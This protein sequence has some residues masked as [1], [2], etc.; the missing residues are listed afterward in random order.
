MTRHVG[1]LLLVTALAYGAQSFMPGGH[2]LGSSGASLGF[3][4]LLIAGLQTGHIFRKLGL[5]HLTG[6]LLCGMFFGP[7]VLGLVSTAMLHDL[8]LVKHVAV[9]LIALLAGCELNVRVLRPSLRAIG[10][11]TFAAATAAALLL[12]G[13]FLFITT[14]LPETRDLSAAQRVAIA[15]VCA[16]VLTAFSP[17]V[18][19]G[20]LAE[21]RAVGPLSRLVLSIVVFADLLIA[22][23]FSITNTVAAGVLPG[24][25]AIAGI[26]TL[27]WQVL[28]SL[29]VGALVGAVLGVY[30]TRV[31]RRSGL[32]V[33]CVLFVVAEAGIAVGIDSLLAGLAAGVF[34][35]NISPVSGSQVI[36]ETE[37]ATLPTFVIFF[38]VIGAEIHAREFLAVAPWA[39]AAALVRATGIF[40]GVR[41]ALRA[42]GV[43]RDIG[44]LVPFGLLPQAGVA[45]AL[46][47]LVR[48][49]FDP[50][51]RAVSTL[52]LGTIVVNELTGPVLFRMALQRANEIPAAQTPTSAPAGSPAS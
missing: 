11:F 9:G 6:Y 42:S 35:E 32:V 30:I 25:R 27:A 20:I 26:E 1:I 14:Q 52:L 47:N 7:P 8:A 34:L 23:A 18:V 39:L 51:G 29:A 17:A 31:G 38:G 49:A 48:E 10:G 4:F 40:G 45:L 37:P 13:L 33:L 43:P 21:T 2:V 3:G 50:W 41:L 16:N 28:M 22:V 46:A 12:F 19:M 15:A 24:G 44:G 36:R 5:P